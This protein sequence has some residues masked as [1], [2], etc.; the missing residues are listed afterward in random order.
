MLLEPLPFADVS[1]ASAA[2]THNSR[3]AHWGSSVEDVPSD[4]SARTGE[5]RGNPRVSKTRCVIIGCEPQCPATN[6][7]DAQG[8][9]PIFARPEPVRNQVM[10][11]RPTCTGGK[12]KAVGDR[13]RDPD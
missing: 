9:Q 12:D 5:T 7:Q 8:N 3:S 11:E 6:V 2:A 1:L 10:S 4:V 13:A